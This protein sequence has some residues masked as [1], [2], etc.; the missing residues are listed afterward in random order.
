MH[1][2]RNILHWLK[3][4]LIGEE[5]SNFRAMVLSVFFA[6]LFWLFN[7]FNGEHS[8]TLSLPVKLQYA[9]GMNTDTISREV[10]FTITGN[11]WQI[12]KEYLENKEQ[13]TLIYRMPV[14]QQQNYVI[15]GS[16][17]NTIAQK[18]DKSLKITEIYTDTFFINNNRNVRKLVKI[19]V[20]KNKISLAEGFRISSPIRVSPQQVV[21]EGSVEKIN[22]LPDSIAIQIKD[23]GIRKNFNKLISLSYLET[24]NLK[25]QESVK[26]SFE[27]EQFISKKVRSNIEKVNFPEGYTLLAEQAEIMC[28]F[29]AQVESE[30]DLT[31][32]KVIADFNKFQIEDST[33]TLQLEH[34]PQGIEDAKVINPHTKVKF[35]KK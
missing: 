5:Q 3:E 10:R 24:P 9:N 29:K 15:A 27:V 13:K 35:H 21:F 18:I 17:R 16:L 31:D 12:M 20:D 32:F 33:I 6:T 4:L 30:I 2:F 26:V 28:V 34:I 19:V 23:L 11:G 7:T 1:F 14:N 22:Q 8:Y 25:A